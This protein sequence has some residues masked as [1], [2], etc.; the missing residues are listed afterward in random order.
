MW[1]AFAA[2]GPADAAHAL[3][4]TLR[5]GN[6]AAEK[7]L[8]TPFWDYLAAHPKE[9]EMFDG[10]MRQQAENVVSPCVAGLPWPDCGT[11]ADIGG[12]VGTLL[13]TVLEKMPQLQ[14]ILVEQ[15]QVIAH[16]RTYLTELHVIDRCELHQGD[17]FAP[18]PRADIYLLSFVLHDW[19]DDDAARIL[20][21]VRLGAA[22]SSRLRIFERLIEDDNSWQIS[23]MSDI[24][25]MLLTGGRERTADEMESLLGEVGWEIENISSRYDP[26]NIIDARPILV[27]TILE[28]SP[29][30]IGVLSMIQ[31]DALGPTGVYRTRNRA[32]LLDVSGQPVGEMSLVPPLY[33]QRSLAALRAA[34]VPPAD[35]RAAYL[36]RA[37][38][39]FIPATING[40]SL[41][42]Y[43]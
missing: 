32:A 34:M 6:A 25:M 33:K 9:Q 21:A 12:G 39:I 31:L 8:G 43:H 24:G 3:T 13:A 35:Y 30:W 10:L 2:V 14:G 11:V 41:D 20:S 23:K 38:D 18:P 16:A 22:T 37:A 17:L 40:L 5:T 7:A 28:C 19:P 42:E 15:P 4:H 26:I 29:I 36:A 1:P 27:I